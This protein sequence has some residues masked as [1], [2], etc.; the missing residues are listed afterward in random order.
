[1]YSENIRTLILLG[2]FASA[3]AISLLCNNQDHTTAI[4]GVLIGWI[5]ARLAFKI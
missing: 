1:M 2:A 4:L 3:F 5:A